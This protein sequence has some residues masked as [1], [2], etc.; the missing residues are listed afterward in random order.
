MGKKS[1]LVDNLLLIAIF[2]SVTT[3][4]AKAYLDPGSGSYLLQI[5]LAG[6]FSL[7]LALKTFWRRIVTTFKKMFSKDEKGS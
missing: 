3:K 5:L 1:K 7:L 4:E 2:V 6:F